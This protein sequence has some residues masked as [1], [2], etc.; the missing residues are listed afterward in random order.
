MKN[1]KDKFGK[2]RRLTISEISEG[3]PKD[4]VLSV[5]RY[6]DDYVY[7]SGKRGSKVMCKCLCGKTI[8]ILVSNLK[9][10]KSCGCIGEKKRREK[11]QKFFPVI[12][13]LHGVYLKMINRCYNEKDISYYNYG[14][15]GVVVC[16]E[17]KNN[18]QNFLDWSLSNGYKDG[19]QI[20][21]DIL[22]NGMLYSPE[23]CCWVTR[24][25]NANNTRKN[26]YY[27]HNGKIMTLSQICRENNI[28]YMRVY[29]RVKKLGMTIEEALFDGLYPSGNGSKKFKK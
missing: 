6:V 27:T 16:E 11:T 19:L 12:R 28:K 25:E 3:L 22:G 23:T 24:L 14:A 1:K 5:I 9:R 15:R 29:D 2:V 17:W 4:S 8:N 21:K 7:R 26:I 10:Q 18:Y 13:K 20:D